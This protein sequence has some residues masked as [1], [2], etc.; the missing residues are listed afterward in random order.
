MYLQLNGSSKNNWGLSPTKNCGGSRSRRRFNFF[1]VSSELFFTK[2]IWGGATTMPWQFPEVLFGSQ[3][4]WKPMFSSG[5]SRPISF[6][7]GHSDIWQKRSATAQR[8]CESSGCRYLG[9]R[10]T[11]TLPKADWKPSKFMSSLNM[12]SII[13]WVITHVLLRYFLVISS[14]GSENSAAM[15]SSSNN[16]CFGQI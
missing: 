1:R 2:P 6:I 9:N 4:L 8:F 14:S 11:I 10:L 7:S 5:G 16:R 12:W 13:R 15:P 3:F